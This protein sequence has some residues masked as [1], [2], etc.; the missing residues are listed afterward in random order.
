MSQ[1]RA[2]RRA[3][4]VFFALAALFLASLPAHAR[5][6]TGGLRVV[7]V[8]ENHLARL[9]SYVAH[10]LQPGSMSKEGVSIDPDGRNGSGVVLPTGGGDEEGTS[11]DPNGRG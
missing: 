2:T 7:A 1:N 3:F 5:S 11:I 4:P 9:W 6:A 8:A 10:L